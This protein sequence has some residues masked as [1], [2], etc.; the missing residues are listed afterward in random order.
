MPALWAGLGL[1]P[2]G[3]PSS[4]DRACHVL[5]VS[6]EMLKRRHCNSS[7][8]S[9]D[10]HNSPK[11]RNEETEAQTGQMVTMVTPFHWQPKP[12]VALCNQ[13]PPEPRS[14]HVPMETHGWVKGMLTGRDYTLGT[15]WRWCP[16]G[17]LTPS[18]A[19]L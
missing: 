10:P 8:I 17:P 13:G 4:E 12:P 5:H 15:K 16:C 2:L 3:C 6:F 19:V 18:R 14:P 7:S 9:R 1:F 11:I